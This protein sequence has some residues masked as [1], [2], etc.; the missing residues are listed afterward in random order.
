MLMTNIARACRSLA[1]DARRFPFDATVNGLGSSLLLP[2]GFRIA[3]YRLAGISVPFEVVVESGAYI[4]S[5]KLSMGCGSTINHGCTIENDERV[6]I[7][8]NCGI[9]IRVQ[10]ITTTHDFSDPSVRA[11]VGSARPIVVGDGVWIGSGAIVLAGVT[12][13]DGCVIAAGAVVNRDC[14]PH[15]LYAGVPARLIRELPGRPDSS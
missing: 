1:R 15:C 2:I 8:R 7:G 3:L 10:F 4:R 14:E 12:I 6:S 13:G 11:G 9:G 5:S